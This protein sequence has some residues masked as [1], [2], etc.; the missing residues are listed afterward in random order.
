MNSIL[1]VVLRRM[2]APMIMLIVAYAVSIA[3]LAMIP[4]NDASG[5]PGGPPMSFFH[6]FYFISY[7][8]TTTGYGE[9]PQTLSD[10]QRMWVIFC[11]YLTVI[12]W[13]YNILTLFAILQDKGFRS[14]FALIGFRRRVEHLHEPFHLICG[15][16]ETGALVCNTLDRRNQRFVIVENS[17]QRMQELGLMAW[18]GN[19]PILNGDACL[20]ENLIAAGLTHSHCRGVLALSPDEN[21]NLAVAIAVRLLNPDIPV[22]A[23][24]RSTSVAANMAS[25]GTDHIINPFEIFARR[26]ALLLRA[27]QAFLLARWLTGIPGEPSPEAYHPPHGK[28]I[29]CGFGRFGQAIVR[30][31]EAAGQSIT[32]IDPRTDI[33][34]EDRPHIVDRGTEAEPLIR[35]GL[36]DAVG[37][38]AGTDN[39][40]N[41][42]S[43]AV[44]AREIKSDI[45]VVMRQNRAANN[46]LFEAYEGDFALVTSELVAQECLAILT[47]PL[48]S[49]FLRYVRQQEDDWAWAVLSRLATTSGER[50]PHVWAVRLDDD[51]SRAFC[52]YLRRGHALTVAHLVCDPSHPEETLRVVPLL[53]VR[54]GDEYPLPQ[55]TMPLEFGDALLFAGRASA[56]NR[57]ELALWNSNA[58]DYMLSGHDAPGGWIWHRWAQRGQTAETQ[59]ARTRR[60]EERS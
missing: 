24:V 11:I 54:G 28:W 33:V 60:A 14:A 9:Y 19:P 57:Q 2:R 47:T 39:D 32:L 21:S 18:R 3:G 37:I 12:S 15:C 43:I 52:D 56:R 7:T 49:R 31:L 22:L 29:V 44:T 25:F 30:T 1:F 23:A 41:N 35:A 36:R 53:L 20:P 6:A 34:A 10:G 58:L 17:E 5:K 40:V 50:L 13:G 26:L 59:T 8:A 48:L 27:P 42:L 51:N 55:A 46:P 4:G 16:G 38:V 45:F